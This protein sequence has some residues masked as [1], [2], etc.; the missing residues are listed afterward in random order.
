MGCNDTFFDVITCRNCLTEL[1]IGVQLKTDGWGHAK[2][3]PGDTVDPHLLD[4]LNAYK[5]IGCELETI[6]GPPL[7]ESDPV[8][9][10]YDFDICERP[11]FDSMDCSCGALTEDHLPRFAIIRDRVYLGLR[12]HP[13]DGDAQGIEL[14]VVD[15]TLMLDSNRE[16]PSLALTIKTLAELEAETAAL[17]LEPGFSSVSE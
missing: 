3:E 5:Y 2:Y 8:L 4:T 15:T 1:R 17:D 11:W 6:V 9:E 7:D 13:Q 14:D 12:R 10:P 16:S